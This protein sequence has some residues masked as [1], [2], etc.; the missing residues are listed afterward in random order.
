MRC[1][2]SGKQMSSH[3]NSVCRLRQAISDVKLHRLRISQGIMYRKFKQGHKVVNYWRNFVQHK[4]HSRIYKQMAFRHYL[5]SLR[6]RVSYDYVRWNISVLKFTHYLMEWHSIPCH[7]TFNLYLEIIHKIPCASC[8]HVSNMYWILLYK[9]YLLYIFNPISAV[10][11][12]GS[13]LTCVLTM[14]LPFTC[15]LFLE[16]TNVERQC[17]VSQSAAESY[18][19][20]E[21]GTNPSSHGL[22]A[23]LPCLPLHQVCT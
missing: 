18:N 6:A 17:E 10:L 11:G 14:Q 2:V 9:Y 12:Y 1:Y 19:W 20:S 15:A 3:K 23:R 8:S 16:Y 4:R 21:S 22:L 5:H 7:D 13:L